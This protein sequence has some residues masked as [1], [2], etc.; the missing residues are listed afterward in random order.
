MIMDED[1][2]SFIDVDGKIMMNFILSL[3][4]EGPRIQTLWFAP[5]A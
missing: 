3:N 4:N 1:I 2:T 5:I